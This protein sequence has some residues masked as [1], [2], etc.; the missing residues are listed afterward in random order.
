M[1]SVAPAPVG[2]SAMANP[3]PSMKAQAL[4]AVLLRAPL[5]YRV[6]RQRGVHS[7]R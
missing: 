1:T 7:A 4:L 5:G 2:P 3:F 6:V